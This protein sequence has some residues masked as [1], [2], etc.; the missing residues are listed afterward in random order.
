MQPATR[1]RLTLVCILITILLDMIGVGIVIPI[2]PELIE[3][4]TGGSVASAAVIGGYLVFV[5]AFMQFV[6]SPVLGDADEAGGPGSTAFGP[7]RRN[8]SHGMAVHPR[9]GPRDEGSG[10][11]R[12]PEAARLGLWIRC[13][14]RGRNRCKP[15]V[16]VGALRVALPRD[17]VSIASPNW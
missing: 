17:R 13:G 2:L 15:P 9:P 11:H 8:L 7:Q 10:P 5:Y 6:F 4:L 3:Q 1:S 12:A 14:A 16:N